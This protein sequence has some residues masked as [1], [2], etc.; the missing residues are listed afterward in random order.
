MKKF[1]LA[2]C[3]IIALAGEAQTLRIEDCYTLAKQ[4]YPQAKQRDLIQ[5]SGAY[6]I[7]NIAT[8]YLPQI[9][10]AGQASY[11][12]AVTE[13]PIKV[14]GIDIPSLSKDQ[15]KLYG[16]VTQVVFD[17][18]VIKQQKKIQEASTVVEA[19]TLEVE[20]YK[21]NDRINQLFFG[22]LLVDE[23]LK[24][25]AITKSDVETA[26]RKTEASIANGVALKS[27]ADVL[28][29]EIIKTD[30]KAIELKAMRR[31]Y[32]DMLALFLNSPV[33]ENTVLLKPEPLSTSIEIKRPELSL[34]EKQSTLFDVQQKMITAKNLPKFGL[35]VQGGVGKPALNMLSNKF[36]PY[37]LG[38]VRLNWSLSGWYTAKKERYLLDLKKQ[39]AN[40]QK[41]TFLYNTNMVI[42]QQSSEE[43]KWQTLLQTDNEMIALRT[44]VKNTSLAQ[45]ENGVI[46]SSDYIREVNAEDQAKQNKILH[47]MQLL[48]TQYNLKFTT[49]N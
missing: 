45:L 22:I 41:E 11:Q 9:N 49:S 24:Q 25:T 14:P 20:L 47:E 5:K 33:T 4:N 19:Q 28:K 1:L 21:L 3:T 16:E 48:Q 32:A 27:S 42:K 10:I 30:Q 40:I 44:S 36:E 17:G 12:S 37:Y 35:F 29:A 38:G 31:A 46:T 43:D 39:N 15:Y 18:G 8:G 34:Y 13:V 2:C 7:D 6:S 23:Q 26:F